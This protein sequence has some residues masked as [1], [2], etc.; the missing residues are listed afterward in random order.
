MIR[1]IFSSDAFIPKQRSIKAKV[2][3]FAKDTAA[4]ACTL[5]DSG[6]IENF[7]FPSFISRYSISIHLLSKTR[8]V[9]NVNGT[10]NQNGNIEETAD[11][12]LNYLKTNGIIKQKP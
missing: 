12:E 1:A 6:V 8:T 5:I 11:L 9:R 4:E 3:V 7:I 10:K 2:Q